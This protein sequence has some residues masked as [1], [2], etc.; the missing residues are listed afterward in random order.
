MIVESLPVVEKPGGVN[1]EISIKKYG[2]KC[3]IV[4]SKVQ[5]SC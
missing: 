1:I 2:R 5:L 3:R 4:V